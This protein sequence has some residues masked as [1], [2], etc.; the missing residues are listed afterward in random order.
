MLSFVST[1]LEGEREIEVRME[2]K[3]RE[4]P[5]SPERLALEKKSSSNKVHYQR[6]TYKNKG[7][8]AFI[9]QA[10]KKDRMRSKIDETGAA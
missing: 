8:L 10:K 4:Q 6:F 1:R 5:V 2:E 9:S 3:R 7:K